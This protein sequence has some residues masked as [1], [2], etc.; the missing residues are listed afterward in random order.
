M[1][2][3][4]LLVDDEKNILLGFRRN[5]RSRHQIA[6]A[7]G[8]LEG[9]R[10]LKEDGP[11]AVVVSDM[12]MPDMSG[13]E[14]LREAKLISPDTIRI[15]LTGN[16]DQ[17]TAVDAVNE[18]AIYR[19]LNKPLPADE[20]ANV[21]DDALRRFDIEAAEKALLS[22]T[23]TGAISLVS[24]AL[25]ISNPCAFGRASRTRGLI[26]QLA[27]SLGLEDPWQFEVA[28]M[29][30]QFGCIGISPETL[31]KHAL[32]EQ[33]SVEELE[34]LTTQAETGSRLVAKLPRLESISQMIANQDKKAVEGLPPRAVLG[35]K[36]LRIA[37]DFDVLCQRHSASKAIEIMESEAD[38]KYDTEILATFADIVLEDVDIRNY[39]VSELRE[40]M[41]LDENVLTD[42]GDILISKGHELTLSLIQTH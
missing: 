36:M 34:L 25:S 27:E 33:L 22:Q 2:A 41:I 21:L 5:L 30:S 8:G 42:R 19:F 10:A 24:E 12:Q 17:Q 4:I 32:G 6:T 26:K 9:L 35:S 31:E 18:G 38:R 15:M 39:K 29:L 40:K 16:A 23:L 14:L 3:K 20:L 28:A 37:I 1:T 13:L 7:E 11:F